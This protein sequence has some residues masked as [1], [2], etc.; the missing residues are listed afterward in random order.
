[1]TKSWVGLLA[2]AVLVLSACHFPGLV[3]PEGDLLHGIYL[4][5]AADAPTV[6]LTFDDGP[7]G[8]C[9]ADV[10]DAL[11]AVG[12]PATFFVLGANVD[13]GG[14]DEVL[15]RMVREGHAIGLHG[16]HHEG[17][18][19]VSGAT[20]HDELRRATDALRTALE[21]AGAPAPAAPRLYRPPFGFLTEATAAAAAGDGFVVVLWTVSV[22]DWRP[23]TTADEIVDRIL[24]RI[25]PGDVIV[26]HD[27]ERTHQ[28][29]RRACA[30]RAVVAVAV[31]A[32][33]PALAARGLRVAPLTEVLRLPPPA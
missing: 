32:L 5:G 9:T 30:D 31:R 14:N 15:A 1:M 8:R 29:D 17:K 6:A 10:L 12:A 20:L 28:R 22:G 16:Y 7:N 19:L 21:R 2:L 26:L 13:A 18:M 11:A 27:G 4:R 3:L 33:V 25:G 24:A 23:H